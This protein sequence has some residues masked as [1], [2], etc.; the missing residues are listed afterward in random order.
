MK[1]FPFRSNFGLNFL[2]VF[3]SLALP[4]TIQMLRCPAEFPPPFGRRSNPGTRS[5]LSRLSP[6]L[7]YSMSANE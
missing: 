5:D 3:G 7:A 2:N 1:K 4:S 6:K